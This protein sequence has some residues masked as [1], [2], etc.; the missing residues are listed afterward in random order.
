MSPTFLLALIFIILTGLAMYSLHVEAQTSSL[1]LH[2]TDNGKITLNGPTPDQFVIPKSNESYKV[3]FLATITKAS[4]EWLPFDEIHLFC[5]EFLTGTLFMD[6]SDPLSPKYLNEEVIQ[7]VNYPDKSAP[8][9]IKEYRE[10]RVDVYPKFQDSKKWF[11]YLR[12]PAWLQEDETPTS[13]LTGKR[14]KFL[15][16]LSFEAFDGP[17]YKDSDFFKYPP[18]IYYFIEP[19]TKLISVTLQM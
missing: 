1:N 6:Y 14:M 13:P 12:T 18:Y 11:G 7:K 9:E 4:I 8:F 19:E 2:A 5:P 3:N 10:V 15:L 16:Q 17:G